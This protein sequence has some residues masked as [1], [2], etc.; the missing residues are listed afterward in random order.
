MLEPRLFEIP[1]LLDHILS[2]LELTDLRRSALLVKREWAEI[3]LDFLWYKVDLCVLL[4]LLVP[5]SRKI[6]AKKGG[7]SAEPDVYEFDETPSL[8]RLKRFEAKYAPR[9]RS[10][11]LPPDNT[12]IASILVKI[13]LMQPKLPL[14][15]NLIALDWNDFFGGHMASSEACAGLFMH[16]RVQDLGNRAFFVHE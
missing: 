8:N 16:E 4:G 15:P 6:G 12:D 9:V 3:C 7:F 2:H 10:I 13:L 11:T 14:L 1:E 5:I